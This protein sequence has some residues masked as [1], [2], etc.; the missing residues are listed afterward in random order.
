MQ[1]LLSLVATAAVSA[2]L[3]GVSAP[4]VLAQDE[5][6]VPAVAEDASAERVGPPAGSNR[7]VTPESGTSSAVSVARLSPTGPAAAESKSPAAVEDASQPP[8]PARAGPQEN[9]QD[10]PQEPKPLTKRLDIQR[11]GISVQYPEDWSVGPKRFENMDELINLPPGQQNRPI[12]AKI[13]ITTEERKD[14]AEALQR[15]EEIRTGIGAPTS[16]FL[17]IGGWPA[18]Q[19]GRIEE[20]PTTGKLPRPQFKDKNMYRITTV[21]AAGDLLVRLEASLP[22]DASRG[23][24][25][26]VEAM[27]RSALFS[28][29]ASAKQT[30]D[31]L[32][33]LRK[34]ARP[35]A[36]PLM[37]VPSTQVAS[38]TPLPK[39]AKSSGAGGGGAALLVPVT[40]VQ[41]E[42][43]Q[44]G[45]TQRVVTGRR[46]E[47]EIAVSPNGQ[48]IVIGQQSVWRASNDGG[49]TFAFN[50][51][52]NAF[53][54]GDPSLGWGQSGAFYY[55]GIDRGCQPADMAGPQGYSCTGMARSTDNGQTFPLVTPAVVCPND[56]ATPSIPGA[57][58]PD[59]EHIAVDRVNAG[60]GAV[61]DQV[62]S[63][64]RNFDAT[65][66]DPGLVC[67][68]DGGQTWSAPIVVGTGAFPRIGVGQDGF[69]YVVWLDG[70][71]YMMRKYSSCASGL[72]SV[73]GP[74]VITTRSPIVCPFPGHDRCDQNPSS[75]TIAVDDTNPNHVYF[76]YAETAGTANND[77]VMVRDSLDGGATW[78]ALRVAQVSSAIPG[79]RIMP[80]VCTTGGEAFVTWY[81]RRSAPATQNDLTEYYAGRARLDGAS[82]LVVG[83]EIKLSEVGDP[84]C[85]SG[86]P[87]S[88]RSV[89]SAEQCSQQPQLAGRCLDAMGNGSGNP[90]DFSDGGCPMGETC[91]T[92]GGCPKYGDYNG[93]ACAAG[94]ILAAY[95]SATA[96]PSITPASTG[97]D[98][99]FVSKVVGDVPQIQIPGDIFFG[100]VCTGS[101]GTQTLNVCNTGKADLEVNSIT[102][103]DSQFAVTTPTQGYPVVISPDFCFPF[104][105]RF[106]PTSTG[107]KTA[108]L[109]V[110]SNDP[111]RPSVT[112]QASGAGTR[113][114]IDTL[115]ANSGNFGQVCVGSFKDLSL[116]I[117]NSGGCD[118]VV[119]SVTSTGANASEF[120]VAGDNAYPITVAPGTSVQVPIRFQP[121]STG[122]KSATIRVNSNDP[123]SPNKDVAVSGHSDPGD[124][125]VTGSTDFGAVCG[126][127]QAEKSVSICN[128]ATACD[129]HV[130]NVV[131][132]NAAGDGAC[133]DFTL[134]NNP[135][136]ATV[137]H[138]S[139][140]ATVIRFTP[141]SA[142]PK[143]CRLVITSDDPD[144]PVVVQTVTA[145]TPL[146]S[147]DVSP[148][149]SFLPEVIQSLGFCTT[150]QPFPISNKGM[151][152][153]K[154]TDVSIVGG[155]PNFGLSALP[156]FPV[157]LQPGHT[158]GDGALQTVFKPLSPVARERAGVLSVTYES[159]PI[160]HLLTTETRDLCG[161]AVNTGA[162]VL[163]RAGGV[164]VDSVEVIKIQRI[165]ANRNKNNVDT[166]DNARDL[167]LQT[168]TYPPGSACAPFQYHREY[169]TASNP[170]QLLP[171]S[172]TVTATAVVNGRRKTK[173]VAFDVTTCDFNPT[174]FVDF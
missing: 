61:P 79:K 82:N 143:Q 107:S 70:G 150:L 78:P 117:N 157:I 149:Q 164:P 92:G 161:E 88:T 23:L 131:L 89:D 6:K 74:N 59:Q 35:N 55:A 166:V 76:S 1:R 168:F 85:A 170:I 44:P 83:G 73:I 156:S 105:V 138:D 10:R 167:P 94:R 49:Q 159:D 51:T 17:S 173:T 106:T 155:N 147:I 104:Q 171:G 26:Q 151:C 146:A 31:E 42:L 103:S 158:V 118:L 65:D 21:I 30:D 57:C 11:K 86:W 75:Q 123:N 130:T 53:D 14:H 109:T 60:T 15:L 93:N 47:L 3:A 102:S 48:N 142:G 32:G 46:G 37:V 40:E 169:G 141:T 99:F 100:D 58:F 113:Q 39:S 67:S 133:A 148:D 63:T 124:I 8:A 4:E 25:N 41:E 19:Y 56:T 128:V 165:N 16:A 121:T 66:Q 34:N 98:I 22:S 97:I 9:Q 38:F 134:V 5:R 69:V 64:W 54:G 80:W 160:T 163:V 81:D 36:A 72:N 115:V 122:A 28:K 145:D 116:T 71:N 101:G 62:Y 7:T 144:S 120:V 33:R 24:I 132:T 27:S 20:R 108:T 172:Y 13:K 87:C 153:V 29:K 18:I 174:V 154:V 139:C 2:L 68:S 140:L 45:L 111:A 137:S 91:Q 152:P 129:L 84:W 43:P 135:F 110:T 112:V 126:G 119:N 96:P 50:G 52:I 127:T 90:C 162:R 95:A 125:R 114:A 12:T 77:R 136:P